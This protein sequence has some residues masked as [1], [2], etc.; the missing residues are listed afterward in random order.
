MDNSIFLR[1]KQIAYSSPLKKSQN[2]EL[3]QEKPTIVTKLSSVI[4]INEGED[5]DVSCSIVGNPEP[6]IHWTKDNVDIREDH[7]VDIYSDRGVHHLEISEILMSDQGLYTIHAENS[8]GKI[9]A[10]CRIEVIENIDKMKRLKVEGLLAYGVRQPTYKAPEF[11]IKPSNRTVHEGEQFQI[12]AKVIGNPAPQVV[13]IR[14]GK[15]LEDDGYHR[16]YDRNGENYFEIPKISILDSGEYS[17]IATNMMGAVYSTFTVCVEAMTEPE[18]TSSEVEERST[19]VSDVDANAIEDYPQSIATQL[20]DKHVRQHRQSKLSDQSD[21]EY[22]LSNFMLKDDFRD[23]ARDVSMNKGDIVEIID[24]DKK[25]KW[26]V[27]NKKNLNQI[28]YVPPDYLE[29]IPD[30]DINLINNDLTTVD[31]N[32]QIVSSKRT[33]TKKSGAVTSNIDKRYNPINQEEQDS[34]SSSDDLKT[35]TEEAE[36]YYANSDYVPTR[37]DGIALAENQL[38]DVLD[39]HD[40][41]QYLVRTRPRKDERPKIGWVDACFLEKKSTNIGQE[42]AFVLVDRRKGGG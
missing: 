15:P 26:L 27:R 40:P 8:L 30:T 14:L 24:I 28:C 31:S 19:N 13:W 7:R 16:I 17:C 20:I 39:S 35:M 3:E 41:V 6:V 37:P 34:S 11:L 4:R 23:E 32:Q 1:S 22:F 36:V 42:E 5:L 38:V 33:F 9:H 10:E 18:S 12:F 21:I 29:M 25:E 2:T